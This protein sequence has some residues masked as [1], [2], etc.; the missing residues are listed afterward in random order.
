MK[1]KNLICKLMLITFFSFSLNLFCFGKSTQS[2]AFADEQK[3]AS[4]IK[5][6]KKHFENKKEEEKE[7]ESNTET[8]KP[9]YYYHHYYPHPVYQPTYIYEPTYVEKSPPKDRAFDWALNDIEL[10]YKIGDAD[11]LMA[12]VNSDGIICEVPDAEPQNLTHREF[13]TKTYN[14]FKEIKGKSFRFEIKRL[15]SSE[16]GFAEGIHTYLDSEEKERNVKIALYLE[17]KD[18]VWYINQIRFTPGKFSIPKKRVAESFI[19]ADNSMKEG[20]I[21]YHQGEEKEEDLKFQSLSVNVGLGEYLGAGVNHYKIE[22]GE[23]KDCSTMKTTD[24][25]LKGQFTK[26]VS[27]K[28]SLSMLLGLKTLNFSI[29]TDGDREHLNRLGIS[30]GGSVC[31]PVFKYFIGHG[32]ILGSTFSGITLLDYEYGIALRLSSKINLDFSHRDLVIPEATL[33]SN[34]LGIEIKF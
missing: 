7:E 13:Y 23:G 18:N 22:E 6:F 26:S 17:N 8:I 21:S 30:L 27:K 29:P 19:Y 5:E 12:Y 14:G 25:L 33:G 31:F 20:S 15:I 11:L 3:I 32:R 34:L 2:L 16:K 9:E 24:I 10:A 4:K 28:A 1:N